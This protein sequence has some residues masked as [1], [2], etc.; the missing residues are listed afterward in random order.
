MPLSPRFEEALVYATR[1]HAA[2]TRKASSTPYIAHLLGVASLVLEDGGS[3]DEAIAALLHDAVEDQGGAATRA[4]ILRR[5][6]ARITAWIDACTDCDTT[7]KPPWRERKQRLLDQAGAA[8]PEVRRILAADKLHNVRSVI[9]DYRRLGEAI[10]PRFTTGKPGTLW[11]YRV[12]ADL[13]A[14]GA[15][16]ALVEDLRREVAELERLVGL[17]A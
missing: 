10:W 15:P 1:L 5:F 6:G 7:P 3:E 14:D 17:D 13:L 11:F 2:Q 9:A 16:S 8:P 12:M 4:E